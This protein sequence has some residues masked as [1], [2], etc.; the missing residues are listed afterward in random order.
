ML[1]AA[2]AASDPAFLSAKGFFMLDQLRQGA[3]STVSKVLMLLLVISFGIWGTGTFQ[4]YG[5]GTVATVG[6]TEV[7]VQEFA[8]YYDQAQ[9]NARQSGQQV[10]PEQV[11]SA[12]MT[13]AAMDD[14]A[15]EYGLGVSGD[16]VA[17]EIAKNPSFQRPDGTLDP[18][19][20]DAILSS[21][22]MRRDD[23]VHEIR[24]GLVRSQIAD[25]IGAG[26][27]VPQ[28][29]VAALYRLQNEERTISAVVVDASSIEPVGEPNQSDLQ[30]YFDANKEKFRAPEYRKLALLTLD[31]AKIADPNAITDA[32]VAAEYDRRKPSLTQPER[33]NIEQIRFATA[34][35]AS[36][37]MKQVEG[38]QDFSAVAAANSVEVTGL[39]VKTKAEVLDPAIADAAFSAELNKPVLVTEKALE[40]SIIRVTTIEAE[41]VP[42]LEE[43]S[44]RIRQDLAT[45]AARESAHDLYDKV[46]DERAGGATL[47]EAGANLKL[48]YQVIDAVAAD[49][50]AP[51]GTAVSNIPEGRQV[52]AEAFQSDVGVENSAVRGTGEVWVVYDVLEVI[53]ARDRTLDEVRDEVVKD[54]KAAE[55]EKRIADRAN[56]LFDRLKGGAS[57]ASLATEINKTVQTME[58]VKR[59]SPPSTLS[60]NAISQAFAGPEGHVANAEGNGPERI[61]LKVDRVTAPAF[62]AEAADAGA[63]KAQVSEQLKNDLF[64]TYNRQ[65]LSTRSTNIN[66]TAF[67]QLTGQTQTQ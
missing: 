61:L 38:G 40:P 7:S 17:S 10:N 44:A 18:Q 56:S 23:F 36:A 63:I 8:R 25:T 52:V 54:W 50:K 41:K 39:G 33:R 43:M 60:S 67:Q 30:T 16:R 27:E 26:L 5:A 37:A 21:A 53:P 1:R 51:D 42:T 55:T 64:T 49:L 11:L 6:D 66:N 62:F 19:R 29:L 12:L 45:R 22:G 28:P 15:R 46:E 32:D 47:Q 2:G 31:P 3:Q 35:A 20:L 24:R 58:H 48:P 13:N 34:D 59:N 9:R 4:G 57:L 14:A 65:L